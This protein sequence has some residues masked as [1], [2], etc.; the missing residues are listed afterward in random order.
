MAISRCNKCGNVTEH[1][2]ELVATTIV[3]Q[4]GASA[5]VYDTAYFVNKLSEMYFALRK[6]FN[7]LTPDSSTPHQNQLK[8]SDDSF[9]IHNSDSLSSDAQH[10]PIIQWFKSK[11][12]IATASINAVD[13]TGYF[14]EAAVAIG[15]D[16]ELLGVVCEQI[17]YAQQKEYTSNLIHLDK[18]SKEDV[19]AIEVFVQ[20]LYDHS[21]IARCI[22]NKKEKNI[23][24]VLQNA[25]SVRRFFAGDWLEWFALMVG[26]R[27]C[28]ERNIKFSCA[29]NMTLAF[30][31][32]ENRELDVFF[33]INNNQPLYIECKTGD[34]RQDLDKYV[35]LRK[36]LAIDQRYFI[37]CVVDLDNEQCKGLTAMYGM[38][39]VNT[40]TLGQHLTSL[41]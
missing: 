8:K 13:T 18:K 31:S 32:N 17:R 3:C 27:I 40:Q 41:L 23:R 37:L 21:L 26:L 11:N 36:R 29:R 38:T 28:K 12:I 22:S 15:T 2:R 14:D 30:P 7:A 9:D 1:E 34:F 10:A 5:A 20:Q 25:P 33:L 4:C 24:V 6:E 39:F 16:Y 35:A 19:K